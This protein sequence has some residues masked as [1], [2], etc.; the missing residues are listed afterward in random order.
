MFAVSLMRKCHACVGDLWWYTVLL[1]LAQR[2]GDVINMFVGLWLV[3]KYV[4]MEEL[5]AVLPL[6]QV[7][8][9]IGIPLAVIATPFSKF[10]LD[11]GARG[12]Y[13]KIKSLLRDVFIG[14]GCLAFLTL[15]FAYLFL[16]LFFERM[17]VPVGSLGILIVVISILSAVSTVFGS[18][19]QGLKLYS[20][21]ILFN[22]LAAPFRLILMLVFMPF[23]PLSGYFVGQGAAPGVGV[24]GALWVLR[25][26]LGRSVKAVPYLKDD[27]RPMVRYAIPFLA[28]TF[29]TNLSGTVDLLV[30]RHRLSDFESAGYYMISRFTDIATYVGSAFVLFLFPMV[31][32]LRAGSPDGRKVL[33]HSVVGT[34]VCGILIAIALGLS[35]NWLMGLA[36]SWRPYRSMSSYMP[37]VCCLNMLIMT[38]GCY[39]SY[40]TAQGRFGFMKWLIP[41]LCLKMAFLYAAT[42]YT[43]F[44]G[45]VPASILNSIEAFNPCRFSFVLTVFI[46]GQLLVALAAVVCF[47]RSSRRD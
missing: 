37:A 47:L 45:V 40:E 14:T 15:L 24:I 3:P 23:R 13:G 10:L 39:F 22:V 9:F 25:R 31:A 32:G 4:P 30:I 44:S 33:L 42:G 12:E 27:W 11:Y 18:A 28:F 6:A 35:G 8:G 17:R 1:F 21:T 38:C 34:A 16:P 19:V 5:G 7:V 2:L 41:I 43:F 46:F 20:A 26:H 29:F 36:E